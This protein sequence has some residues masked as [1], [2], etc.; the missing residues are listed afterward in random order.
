M[1]DIEATVIAYLTERL[2]CT[3]YAEVP[4]PRPERFVTVERTGG[5]QTLMG[6][7]DRPSVAVQSWEA[8]RAKAQALASTVDAL[9]LS[10]PLE[11]ENVF[12]CDRSGPYNYPDPDSRQSRYQAIYELVTT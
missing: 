9:M 10:M 5:T 8:S 2:D 3:A 6:A 11:V 1:M 7:V 12:D 4:N